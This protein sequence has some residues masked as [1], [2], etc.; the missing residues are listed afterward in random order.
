MKDDERINSEPIWK[1]RFQ[2]TVMLCASL[3]W[4]SDRN[5]FFHV[6]A[7][8]LHDM[9]EADTV[10]IRLLSGTQDAF[11]TYATHGERI[12]RLFEE[13]NTLS[14]TAG[15]MPQ[16]MKTLE[17][18]VFDFSSPTEDDIAWES[19]TSDG[20]QTAITV[21]LTNWGTVEGV[22]DLL[23]KTRPD[24][25][26][27]WLEWVS[28]LGCLIGVIISNS[29]MMDE[30]ISMRLVDERRRL[31]S[32][33]HDNL[34]QSINVI[35]FEAGNMEQSL[36]DNDTELLSNQLSRVK[37]ASDS[38]SK[39]VRGE[40]RQLYGGEI[41]KGLTSDDMKAYFQDFCTR[42]GLEL[43]YES[44]GETDSSKVSGRVGVQL[45]RIMNEAMTNVVRHS[46]ATR[47]DVRTNW[48]DEGLSVCIADDGAG[49]ETGKV[50]ADRMGI[51]TMRER[52]HLIDGDILVISE[53]GKGTRV[54]IFIPNLL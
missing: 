8:H 20:F 27:E 7:E 54:N 23:Y 39:I 48:E 50:P 25:D 42:W 49:F 43:G 12:D 2:K 5:Q 18:I 9:T 3:Y 24:I 30:Q 45:I 47:V 26:D 17:P 52:A 4:R 10:N 14:T 22:C 51:R 33:I 44:E 37:Q 35:A 19:G 38:A 1:S 36:R 29:I 6:I 53:P 34:A 15:R 13:F 46:G 21:P 40:V 41:D 32:E 11:V 31:S 28:D 16:L